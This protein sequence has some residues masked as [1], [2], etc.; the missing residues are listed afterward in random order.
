MS[1]KKTKRTKIQ[2]TLSGGTND[3][4]D[5][6][7]RSSFIFSCSA[8]KERTLQRSTGSASVEAG[9]TVMFGFGLI[10]QLIGGLNEFIHRKIRILRS[11]RD[12]AGDR[13]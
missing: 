10:H 11:G 4:A 3:R 9:L 5:N 6:N 1:M 8:M 2:K 7:K 12:A 13:H